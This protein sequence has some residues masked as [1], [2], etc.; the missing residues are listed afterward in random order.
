MWKVCWFGCWEIAMVVMAGL[1]EEGSRRGKA[2]N[3]HAMMA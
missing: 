3:C 2:S 1:A